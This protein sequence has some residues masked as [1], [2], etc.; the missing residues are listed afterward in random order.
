MA[1]QSQLSL[2]SNTHK[3][4]GHQL[5]TGMS[6]LLSSCS[7][8]VSF[9]SYFPYIRHFISVGIIPLSPTVGI[10]TPSSSNSAMF[11]VTGIG[12]VS[13]TQTSSTLP[14]SMCFRAVEQSFDLS[15][16]TC[17]MLV[18]GLKKHIITH[19]VGSTSI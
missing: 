3:K 19:Q 16:Q 9:C 8:V 17:I 15:S 5:S 2:L 13:L 1:T 18:S 12:F 11:P 14:S 7:V 4:I 6:K 10:S